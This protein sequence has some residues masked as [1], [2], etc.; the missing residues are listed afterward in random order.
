[1]AYL[2][3]AEVRERATRI[4]QRVQKSAN[5][6]LCEAT[7]ATDETFDVF[8]SHSSAEP[9]EILLGIRAMLED[10]GLKV[11]VDKYSDPQL[12]PDK[13]T[14][15]TAEILRGRMHQSSTL[16]Y[17]YSPHSKTSRWM[18]WELGF[19]DALKGAIGIIPVTHNQEET[20]KGEEYLN[21]YPYV[22][23]ATMV[24]TTEKRLWINKSYNVYALLDGWVKGTK[25]ISK[26]D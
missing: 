21:L 15:E 16:L 2:T 13:V 10:R 5:Q 14:P 25:K 4:T 26:H 18:P 24:N 8:L 12:L 20:F 9:E 22:D 17:V 7:A 11:Y 19:F 6:V 23:V 1:M 3:E